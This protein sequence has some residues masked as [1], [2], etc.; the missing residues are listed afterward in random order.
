MKPQFSPNNATYVKFHF[1]HFEKHCS[2]VIE[3]LSLFNSS[4]YSTKLS[5]PFLNDI[6]QEIDLYYGQI[7]KKINIKYATQIPNNKLLRIPILMILLK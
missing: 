7:K 5:F 4:K 1:I 3:T 6:K 2:N